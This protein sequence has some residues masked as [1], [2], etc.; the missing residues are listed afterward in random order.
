MSIYKTIN[1]SDIS[2]NEVTVH[3]EQTLNQ[4]S[5]VQWLNFKS[6]SAMTDPG[7]Y[8]TSLLVNF[9]LSGSSHSKEDSRFN[10][11]GFSLTNYSDNNPIYKN[12]FHGIN[13]GSIISIPQDYF[14]ETI[15]PSS[16]ELTD[17]SNGKWALKIVDDGYGNL[18]STN[19]VISSSADTAL[20]SS[21]NYVGNIFYGTG[22][23]VITETGSFSGSATYSELGTDYVMKF[24]STKTMYESEYSVVINPNEFNSTNNIT[25]HHQSSPGTFTGQLRPNLTASKWTPYF[26]TVGFYDEGNNLV[27]VARYPQ[28][29][30]K[31]DDIS[32]TLTVKTDW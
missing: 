15:K 22:V 17:H 10:N 25:A 12:K 18:Y 8:W 27:M 23:A 21:E 16:F 19:P 11:P 29:I 9:Y 28:N 31:R 32:L 24:K 6:G 20:S 3:K 7:K 30:K 5:N 26:N 13:S 2:T 1:K 4:N 14:G